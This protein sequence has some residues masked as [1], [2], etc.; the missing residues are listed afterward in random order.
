MHS[1]IVL[2]LVSFLILSNLTMAAPAYAGTNSNTDFA[3]GDGSA[4]NPYQIT[5]AEQLDKVRNYLDKHFV[6][7]NDI[8]LSDYL[9]VGG[10]GY[11]DGKGREPIGDFNTQKAFTGS[12]YGANHVVR[13]LTNYTSSE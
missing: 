12:L 4:A 5:T 10:A 1:F 8:D 2:T 6:L 11:N 9:A 13:N 7:K 3:G